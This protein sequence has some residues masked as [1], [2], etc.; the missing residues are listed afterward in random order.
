MAVQALLLIP[1]IAGRSASDWPWCA[2][3]PRL[4]VGPSFP[5]TESKEE[6]GSASR[7]RFVLP[8]RPFD[9]RF[10]AS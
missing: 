3:L 2:G 5:A 7:L 10:K 9:V 6:R 4:M 1:P 8:S